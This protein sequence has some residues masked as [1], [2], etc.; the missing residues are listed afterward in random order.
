MQTLK[1]PFQTSVE[2]LKTIEEYRKQYSSCLHLFYNL[3]KDKN[4]TEHQSKYVNFNNIEKMDAWFI[5]S[6]YKEAKQIFDT[7][8]GKKVIFGGRKN[9]FERMKGLITEETF[10]EK[11]LPSLYSAGDKNSKANRKFKIISE[12][13]IVFQPKKGI[14]IS[15]YLNLNSKSWLEILNKLKKLQDLKELPISYKLDSK[16]VYVVFDE[17]CL[18]ENNY[19]SVKNRIFAIDLNPNYVGYSVVDWVNENHFQMIDKGVFSLKGLN[20]KEKD[21]KNKQTYFSNKRNFEVMEISK[22]LVSMAKNYHCELFGIEKLNIKGKDVGRGKKLNRLINNQW[23]RN[24]LQSN[25][26]KRCKLSGVK[27]I[28]V[29]P[30]YS[31]FVGNMVYR[32]LKLPDMI[33]S[34]LEIGRRAYEFHLQYILKEKEKKENIIFPELSSTIKRNVVQSLEELKIVSSWVALKELYDYLKK[35]KCRY[36]FPLE[37]KESFSS[38]RYN[39]IRNFTTS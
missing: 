13:E 21:S 23:N 4:L 17:S 33:L 3:I 22:K 18:K 37:V 39:H 31:S 5:L 8:N 9:F 15:L 11:R 32:N 2:N 36:R 12:K 30:Q 6:C 29:L 10:Q 38:F 26:E 20:D 16:F 24:K 28:E 7:N 35:S 19:K 14:K 25:I 34:S 27:Y 1:I